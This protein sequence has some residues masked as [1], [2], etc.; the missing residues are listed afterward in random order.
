MAWNAL[1]SF[2]SVFWVFSHHSDMVG[3]LKAE[4]RIR[5][6]CRFSALLR[7]SALRHFNFQQSWNSKR[8]TPCGAFCRLH[9][10][11]ELRCFFFS[12]GERT[13]PLKGVYKCALRGNTWKSPWNWQCA[14]TC[15]SSEKQNALVRKIKK[16]L[17]I[18]RF[19]VLRNYSAV[20]T[21]SSKALTLDEWCR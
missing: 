15:F 12:L 4:K 2:L 8:S 6:F 3:S 16:P 1:E 5:G 18:E 14:F 13:H 7:R 20:P 11:T 21:R 9:T 17:M 19:Y 10:L